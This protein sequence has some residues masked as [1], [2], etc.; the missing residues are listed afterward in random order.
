MDP[1]SEQTTRT[2][3]NN[4]VP[5]G[6][7]DVR[8]QVSPCGAL[9]PSA[10]IIYPANPFVSHWKFERL[11][12][13]PLVFHLPGSRRNARNLTLVNEVQPCLMAAQVERR[14]SGTMYTERVTS[15]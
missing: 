2:S 7:Q 13:T 8:R 12:F 15:P 6:R 10:P 4:I 5:G 11:T 14:G 1:S 9:V 3:S